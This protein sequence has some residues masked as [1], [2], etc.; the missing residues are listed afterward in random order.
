MTKNLKIFL[1]TLIL[2]FLFCWGINVLGE[3]LEDFLFWREMAVNPQILAAQADQQALEQK[4]RDLRPIRNGLVEDLKIQARSVISVLLDSSAEERILFEKNISRRLPI[5]SLTKLMTAYIILENYDME[6]LVQIS[7]EAAEQPGLGAGK[8]K[9][10]EEFRVKD[11]LYPMLMESNN[12]AAYAL[13]SAIGEDE[14]VELMN[15]EAKGLGLKNTHFVN[16]TGLDP[17]DPRDPLNYSTPQDLVR[18]C[19]YL[20]KKT[21]F[22]WGVLAIPEFD[23]YAPDG[24]FHHQVINTNEFLGES[25]E[26][27]SW[28]ERLVGGKTGFTYEAGECFLLVL[29]APKSKGYLINV[30]LGSEDRFGEMAQLTNWLHRAYKW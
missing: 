22:V 6:K 27:F 9:V 30:I 19:E 11:L 16:S 21:P 23:L 10:G 20:F 3:N 25:A 26:N 2:S 24:V 12:A 15:L 13:S 29:G 8:L 1:T 18:L 28:Q 5:A 7:Q 17:D 14:F 4:L